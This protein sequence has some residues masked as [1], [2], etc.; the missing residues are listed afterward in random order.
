[1]FV[2]RMES[3]AFPEAVRRVADRFG[4]TLPE[5]AGPRGR[6]AEPLVAVNA[7]AAAFYQAALAGPLGAAA[8]DYV[9]ERG[10]RDETVGRFGLGYAPGAGEALARHLRGRAFPSED[11][12]S[13]GLVLRRDRPAGAGGVFDRFRDRLI[14][15]ITDPTGKVV[16]FGGRG[17]SRRP[18]NGDPP[19]QDPNPP[20][21]PPLPTGPVLSGPFPAP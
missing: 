4:I 6:V 16:A 14:F 11:A 7:A 2:M 19:P 9:R 1:A 15:P 21:A 18:P 12:V 20:H 8:R 13:A 3:L 5:T 10:L 17:L